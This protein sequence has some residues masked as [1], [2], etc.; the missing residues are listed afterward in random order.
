MPTSRTELLQDI[1]STSSLTQRLLHARLHQTD[2]QDSLS[3]AQIQVL[4]YMRHIQPVSF[5]ALASKLH[6]TPGAITQLTDPL[7]RAG[8]VSRIQDD[9][10]R[11]VAYI[12]LTELGGERV[13]ELKKCYR[14]V[15]T[16]AV[17]TLDTEELRALLRIQRKMLAYLE[18]HVEQGTAKGDKP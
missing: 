14:A 5:K 7:I 2:G 15:Y 6:L 11:R 17:S 4:F 9:K 10:D 16:E 1:F 3:P 18:S 12:S 8:Y 13:D